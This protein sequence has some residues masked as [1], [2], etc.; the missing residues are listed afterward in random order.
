MCVQH[1]QHQKGDGFV[2][3]IISIVI[4]VFYKIHNSVV[5]QIL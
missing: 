2:K 3:Q 4:T 5:F 1:S